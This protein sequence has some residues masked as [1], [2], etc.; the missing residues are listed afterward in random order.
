M[1]IDVVVKSKMIIVGT[2]M[3]STITKNL[4]SYDFLANTRLT[5]GLFNRVASFSLVIPLKAMETISHNIKT[6][7]KQC[8]LK[9][10]IHLSNIF[11]YP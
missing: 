1:N 9:E 4:L 5:L 10:L 3:S 6:V 11:T 8:D 2:Y 7:L